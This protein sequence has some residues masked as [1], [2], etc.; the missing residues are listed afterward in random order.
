[1][2]CRT[3]L[4]MSCRADNSPSQVGPLCGAWWRPGRGLMLS[5]VG[6]GGGLMWGMMETLCGTWWRPYVEPGGGLMW[7]LAEALYGAL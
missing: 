4:L 7:S 2:L 1:M 5:L 6:P 3:G